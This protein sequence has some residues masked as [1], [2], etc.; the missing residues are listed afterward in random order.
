MCLGMRAVSVDLRARRVALADGTFADYDRLIIATGARVRTSRHGGRAGLF[1]LRGLD[2]AIV[3]RRALRT[4]RVVIGGGSHRARGRRFLPR[5]R[6]ASHRDRV[7]PSHFPQ[8][9]GRL[10]ATWSRPCT[11]HGVDLRTGVVVTDVLGES[12]VAGVALSDGSRSTP[13]SWWSA[14]ASLQTRNGSKAAAL[15]IDTGIVCNGS[16][17][18]APDVYAAGD[19]A[20]V[21]NRWHGDSPRIEHWTNAVE[22]AVHA[23]ENALAGPRRLRVS[24]PCPLLVGPA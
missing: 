2:D 12:R 1:T 7:A 23:A 24:R 13:T 11:D 16:G 21:A 8:S 9:L 22:Q 5:P 18:A 4:R 14:S 3:L 17:E 6:P 10:S 20:R 19:V 15:T